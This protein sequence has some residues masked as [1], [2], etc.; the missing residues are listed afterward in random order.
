MGAQYTGG[1]VHPGPLYQPLAPDDPAVVGGHRTA[2]RLGVGALGPV[3]LAYAPD[4]HPVALTAVRPELAAR[5][6]FAAAFEHDVQAV[7]R[8]HGPFTVPVL[9]SGHD[10]SRYWL[11][12]GYV[13][14]LTLHAAVTGTGRPLPV[15]VVLRLVA[16]VA[17]ALRAVHHAGVVH[18]GLGPG[19]VLLAA[20]GPRVTGYGVTRAAADAPGIPAFSAP[21]QAAD[22]PPVPATD[23]FALG[24][25][26]AYAAVG[27]PPFGTRPL[28][29]E[30]DLS[31]LPGELRE[32]V[33]RCLIKDP[34]LR[35]SPSQVIAMCAQATHHRPPTPWL[36]TPLQTLLTLPPPLPPLPPPGTWPHPTPTPA[37]PP[38][39]S[40]PGT[41]LPAAPGA[42]P[43][44]GVHVPAAAGATS[45][46]SSAAPAVP[47]GAGMQLPAAPGAFPAGGVP[48][49][50]A[51]PPGGVYVPA[52]AGGTSAQS[53][54]VPAVPPGAGM[55]PPAVPGATPPGG[56]HLPAAAGGI[57]TPSTA[58]PSPGRQLPVA[59]G[60]TRAGRLSAPGATPPGGVHQPA[61]PSPAAP[62]PGMQPPAAPG[63]TPLGGMHTL[64]PP[65][66][67]SAP[68]P[69][70][71]AV[72]P[73]AGMQPPAAPR[74]TPVPAPGGATPPGGVHLHPVVGM[75]HASPAPAVGATGP[76]AR[77]AWRGKGLAAVVAAVVI[78]G[79]VGFGH[80]LGRGRGHSVG[81]GDRDAGREYR[82]V[83]LAAGTG[84]VLGAEPPQSRAGAANGTFGYAED[85]E[86]FVSGAA[87]GG[88]AVL[89]ADAPGT[90]GGCRGEAGLVGSVASTALA[91]GSRLCV[92]GSDGTTALVTLRQLT[93]PGGPAAHATLDLTVWPPRQL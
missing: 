55:Q 17:E 47:P 45:A 64:A 23:V 83:G 13:P 74:A 54:A 89:G 67:T 91:E 18:A 79:V 61:A 65:G 35:P 72:P 78:V 34:A 69:A 2:A 50:G 36:P 4:G 3:Y 7:R 85:G 37:A 92:V 68:S 38:R 66:G 88:L 90:L 20:D 39:S 11:A 51:T 6:G 81:V 93:D 40:A 84:L 48:V 56:V 70:A 5:S 71:P 58:A 32:I 22:Q 28:H 53:P 76:G 80:G 8:V 19:T 75:P 43:P 49:P 9:G 29:E 77:A 14:A 44:G 1:E 86:S 60:A 87:G 27:F 10:G 26:A 46:P 25:L 31:E 82:G 24:Q 57:R 30:P 52:A 42:T 15:P 33:T 12:A 73:G 59:P 16:G 62:A 63:A 41:Q 21:E